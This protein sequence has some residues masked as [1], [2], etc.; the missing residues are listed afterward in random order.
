MDGWVERACLSEGRTGVTPIPRADAEPET[1]RFKSEAPLLRRQ[2]PSVGQAD[3]PVSRK[4]N[5]SRYRSPFEKRPVRIQ[6]RWTRTIPPL[7]LYCS[8]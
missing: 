4:R 6:H 3:P 7:T 5:K 8:T 2:E 1:F